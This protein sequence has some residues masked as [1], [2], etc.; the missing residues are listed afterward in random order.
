MLGRLARGSGEGQG[1]KGKGREGKK[2][3]PPSA[4][5]DGRGGEE[6]ARDE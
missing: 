1:A 2:Q 3:I 4:R 6:V 5:D